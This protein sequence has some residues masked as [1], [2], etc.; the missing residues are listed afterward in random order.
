MSDFS[1]AIDPITN[2][3]NWECDC[4][5]NNPTGPCGEFFKNAFKCFVENPNNPELWEPLMAIVQ[6]CQEEYKHIYI[7]N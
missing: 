4:M 6:K 7:K 2:I 5:G 1:Q 3:I